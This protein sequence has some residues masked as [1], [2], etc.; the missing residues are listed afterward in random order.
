[1]YIISITVNADVS[2]EQQNNMFP[3]HVQWFQTYFH[4]GKFL[5]LGPYVDSD[6]HAGVIFAHTESR[7][8]LQSILEEDCYYPGFAQYDIR[9]FSPKLIAAN[10]SELAIR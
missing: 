1:M 6:A 2:E 3:I 10:I 4:A 9:E 7:E 8:E 5:M